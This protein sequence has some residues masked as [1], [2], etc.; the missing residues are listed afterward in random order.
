VGKGIAGWVAE[1]KEPV[2]LN[3]VAADSRFTGQIDKSS[4]FSTK[5]IAAIPMFA[6]GQLIGVCEALNKVDGGYTD[7]DVKIL[8]N[9]AALAASTINNARQAEDHRNFFSHMIE[10]ITMAIEG[11]DSRQTGHSYRVAQLACRIGRQMARVLDAIRA[12]PGMTSGELAARHGMDRHMVARRCPDLERRG[13]VR[14][15][16][17]GAREVRW[18]VTG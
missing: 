1:H 6:D 2:I 18:E 13:L 14:R 4:G 8:D 15:I 11:G 7:A 10:I 5:S 12:T 17:Y 3:D 9:L 16:E